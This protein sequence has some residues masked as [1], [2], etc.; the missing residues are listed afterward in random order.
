MIIVL[1][2]ICI[3]ASQLKMFPLTMNLSYVW[4]AYT[5]PSYMYIQDSYSSLTQSTCIGKTCIV[6]GFFSA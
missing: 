3:M 6:L 1:C 2:T 5:L 4:C